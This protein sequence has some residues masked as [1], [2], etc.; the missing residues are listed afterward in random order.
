[1]N[2]DIGNFMKKHNG[3]VCSSA[4]LRDYQKS[5]QEAEANTFAAE[6]LM[7]TYSFEISV[8]TRALHW[9]S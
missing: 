3:S 1:M 8:R 4:N 6:L 9:S 2:L 5:P 7:P